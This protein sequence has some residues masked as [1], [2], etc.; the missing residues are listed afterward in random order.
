LLAKI[1]D[2]DD[3]LSVK[4][5]LLGKMWNSEGNFFACKDAGFSEDVLVGLLL[6]KIQEFLRIFS[7]E[8]LL[9]KMW[10]FLRIFVWN[11]CLGRCVI[12]RMFSV[13]LLVGKMQ[14]FEDIISV[15]LLC[16]GR[17]RI[18]RILFLWNFCFGVVGVFQ[19]WIQDAAMSTRVKDSTGSPAFA[20]I[21]KATGQALRHAHEDNEQVLPLFPVFF[22][23]HFACLQ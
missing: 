19:L 3:I 14:D 4:L 23:F 7:G 10:D 2:S 12:L 21:N 1:R 9:G 17:C 5:F 11:F 8:L 18:L 13:Q 22:Q 20:L 15:K 16:F 6:G